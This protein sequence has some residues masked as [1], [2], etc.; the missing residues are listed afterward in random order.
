MI[1]II[2]TSYDKRK[3]EIKSWKT[4]WI[5]SVELSKSGVDTKRLRSLCDRNS[6]FHCIG[7][8]ISGTMKY[9]FEREHLQQMINEANAQTYNYSY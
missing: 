2:N 3:N 1:Q 5:S 9:W 4:N 8:D 6:K 7:F